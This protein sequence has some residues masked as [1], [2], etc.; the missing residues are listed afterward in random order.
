MFAFVPAPLRHALTPRHC[1]RAA[2]ARG[3]R[4][5]PSPPST[6]AVGRP[7]LRRAPAMATPAA[8]GPDGAAAAATPPPPT[9]SAASPPAAA[10][11]AVSASEAAAYARAVTAAFTPTPFVAPLGT[12]NG[13]VQTI[14]GYLLPRPPAVTYARRRLRGADGDAFDV[15]VAVPP[16]VTLPPPAPTAVAD[17][18]AAPDA[19]MPAAPPASRPPR[20]RVV[21]AA[22]AALGPL[23]AGAHPV[24]IV[25]HGLESSSAAVHTLRIVAPLL[26][27]GW[28]VL[29]LNSRG[30][31]GSPATS[32][33]M[34]H[35]SFSDDLG[36]LVDAVGAGVAAGPLGDASRG[37]IGLSGFSLGANIVTHYV[38]TL[39]DRAPA[40]GIRA[41]AVGCVPF[42]PAACQ[43]RI[44]GGICR[45]LYADRFVGTIKAKAEGVIDALG[46]DAAA[47][48]VFDVARVRSA[49]TIG[50]IDDAFI[51]PVFGFDG[52][53]GYYAASNTVPLLRRVAVP[54]LA[55]N[56]RD[57]PFFDPAALPTEAD[58]AGAPVILVRGGA[59]RW[60]ARGGGEGGRGTRQGGWKVSTS[61]AG[62]CGPRR[63][64]AG[65]VGR[66]RRP[67][68]RAPAWRANRHRAVPVGRLWC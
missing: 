46:G 12:R 38:G 25:C 44:D 35:A 67:D 7:L 49:T 40:V 54:L 21:A 47:D 50:D 3:G 24:A 59:W 57:D 37:V 31:S 51:A 26:A 64:V 15:D 5:P 60:R 55:M 36:L 9:V 23:G 53:E 33:R 66:G 65:G 10:G 45:L 19:R 6:A 30:C 18:A 16:G 8:G 56:N 39:G 22:A 27:A 43:P 11:V 4:R 68:L 29:A 34:Y 32:P 1:V 2:A 48:R 41:A 61:T 28:V 58:V 13:H 20:S 42:D 17:A 52:K 62:Q 14:L 63:P